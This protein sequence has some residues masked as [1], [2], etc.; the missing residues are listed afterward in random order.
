MSNQTNC[1]R[2]SIDKTVIVCFQHQPALPLLIFLSL[3]WTLKQRDVGYA[4]RH[5]HSYE[6][7]EVH[8]FRNTYL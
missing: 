8:F 1:M 4:H 2:S 6:E 5:V 7:I 3:I